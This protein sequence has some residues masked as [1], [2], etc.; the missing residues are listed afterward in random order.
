MIANAAPW[1]FALKQLYLAD[2]PAE[3]LFEVYG[4]TELGVNTVLEP[5]DQLRKP[6][7]C[8]KAAPGVE[9]VLFDDDGNE[10]DGHRTRPSGRALRP[11]RLGVFADYYKQ[12][13]KYEADMRG[14]Y[15]TVGD[16]A[17]RDD[18]GYLYICDRKKDMIIS[19]GMNIYP[20]R[21]RSG[22]RAAPEHLRR[23]GLRHPLRGVG[24]VRARGRRRAPRGRAVRGRRDGA[25]TR[26]PR[27]LQGAPQRLVHGRA[28]P[29]GV[30]QDPRARA[31]PRRT[32]RAE[33]HR[34]ADPRRRRA[35][36][37]HAA[38]MSVPRLG[39]TVA[40]TP[41]ITQPVAERDHPV[42]GVP[43][44]GQPGVGLSGM[45]FTWARSGRASAAQLARVDGAGR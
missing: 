13:D 36:W 42:R 39:R 21:D 1:C 9:I 7:S 24:R 11:A 29:H 14:D 43:G 17:Y 3:S 20:G 28:A 8:G 37:P 41:S 35:S 25:R 18:E 12:H 2:F 34:S 6:G 5:K 40:F 26:A 22:A 44:V 19:G 31:A 27:Q 32:G 45:R 33:R 16:V 23:G 38:S 4:S 10:V 30:G 15:H